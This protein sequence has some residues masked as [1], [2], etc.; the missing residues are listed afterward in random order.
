MDVKPVAVLGAVDILFD[1]AGYGTVGRS[2]GEA[3]IH[4]PA[5]NSTELHLDEMNEADKHITEQ[6]EIQ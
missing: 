3:D 2:I 5:D 1:I 4:S 6:Q